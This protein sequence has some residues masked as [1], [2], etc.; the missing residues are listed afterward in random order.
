[1]TIVTTALTSPLLTAL[2][3]RAPDVN[4]ALSGAATP[5]PSI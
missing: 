2:K 4:M 5:R 3:L 1:M